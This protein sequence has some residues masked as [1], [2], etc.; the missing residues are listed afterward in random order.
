VVCKTGRETNVARTKT[1]ECDKPVENVFYMNIAI[2]GVAPA[3]SATRDITSRFQRMIQRRNDPDLKAWIADTTPRLL[4][5]FAPR[6][7]PYR[8]EPRATAPGPGSNGQTAQYQPA[9][10]S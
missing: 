8:A 5:S 4:S 6:I 1:T 3:L 9:Y 10:I 7:G 2:K